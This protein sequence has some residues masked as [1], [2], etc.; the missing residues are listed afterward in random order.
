MVTNE[1]C[2]SIEFKKNYIFLYLLLFTLLRQL[3]TF[4]YDSDQVNLKNIENE[5][6]K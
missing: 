5:L 6:E 3:S 2:K 1:K 4:N